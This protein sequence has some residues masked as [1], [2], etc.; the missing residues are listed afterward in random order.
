MN[1]KNIEKFYDC[2]DQ[3]AMLLYKHNK[4]PYL[5]GIVKTCENIMA[6]EAVGEDKELNDKLNQLIQSIGDIEF[7]KE[8]IRKAFQYAVLKGMKHQNIS[9]QM[10]TPE[11]I[12]MLMGYLIQKLYDV[13]SFRIYDPLVGTGNLITSIANQLSQDVELIGV[14]HFGVSYEL[15]QALFG[16]LGYGEHVFFQDT[17]T[18]K[19][20]FAD[21]IVSDFSAVPQA[22]IYDIINHQ[23]MNIKPNGYFILMVDNAFF[24]ALNIKTFVEEV[25]KQWY[26]FGMMV[27]PKEI[28]KVQE[29]TILILQ[30][31]GDHFIQP[32]SFMMVEIP[33]FKDVKALNYVITQLNQWFHKT[34]FYR[35]HQK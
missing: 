34:K 9:N 1:E 2:I 28:F 13:P 31:K 25:N 17:K 10:M 6:N 12:G 29:K 7:N 11:S 19:N 16:L 35:Y 3:S 14:D 33:E 24:D 30:D 20:I 32:D 4:M 15:S 26:L 22:E 23:T 27:L 18:S 8:E 5:S 21:V